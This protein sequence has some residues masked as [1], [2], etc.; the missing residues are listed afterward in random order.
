MYDP[1]KTTHITKMTE[2]E[3]WL[4]FTESSREQEK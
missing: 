4:F 3:A 2:E 1:L